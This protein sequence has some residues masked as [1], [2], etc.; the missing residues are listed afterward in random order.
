MV[1][2]VENSDIPNITLNNLKVMMCTFIQDNKLTNPYNFLIAFPSISNMT[3]DITI[4]KEGDDFLV[5]FPN[6][7]GHLSHKNSYK[8][9]V[10]TYLYIKWG[11][12]VWHKS[13]IFSNSFLF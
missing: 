12:V 4:S 9:M 6:E 8:H 10:G 5:W 1:T 11:R 13:I 7:Y 2:L 3:K